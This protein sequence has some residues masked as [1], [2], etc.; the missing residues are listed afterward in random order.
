MIGHSPYH[1]QNKHYFSKVSSRYCYF[2]IHHLSPNQ[3]LISP[4]GIRH[5][6]QF[7]IP[8][9]PSAGAFCARLGKDHERRVPG[10]CEESRHRVG[11]LLLNTRSYL[12]PSLLFIILRWLIAFLGDG[13]LLGAISFSSSTPRSRWLRDL[14]CMVCNIMLRLLLYV[15]YAPSYRY[16]PNNTIC[17][18]CSDMSGTVRYNVC[19]R[20]VLRLM[21]QPTRLSLKPFL[22]KYLR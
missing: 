12:L 2:A 6:R 22:Y 20:L 15:L 3:T 19:A 18:K 21:S 14:N 7:T 9:P 10:N 4:F 16:A 17:R 5:I 1:I 13:V 11:E 8:P